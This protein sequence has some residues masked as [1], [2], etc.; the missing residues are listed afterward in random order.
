[1]A[2][3]TAGERSAHVPAALLIGVAERPLLT[4]PSATLP[5]ADWDPQKADRDPPPRFSPKIGPEIQPGWGRSG[6]PSP[7]K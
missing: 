2:V 1:M 6:A 5:E 4:T 3:R 7:S